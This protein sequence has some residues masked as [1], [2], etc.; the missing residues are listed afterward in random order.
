MR[1]SHFAVVRLYKRAG[2][3]VQR[4]SLALFE[5]IMYPSEH[6]SVRL[7]REIRS[8]E[9][10]SEKVHCRDV[11]IFGSYILHAI[12]TQCGPSEAVV[13][14]FRY[15]TAARLPGCF[16][17]SFSVPTKFR[18]IPAYIYSVLW[19]NMRTS[20]WQVSSRHTAARLYN[21]RSIYTHI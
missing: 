10:K 20:F 21:S 11:F 19:K 17:P 4:T 6:R 13:Y 15:L 8:K 16:P 9:V 2:D 7:Q 3:V 12:R 14:Y 5:K 18:R 1:K